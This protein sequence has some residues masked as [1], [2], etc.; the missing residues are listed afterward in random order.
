MSL[1]TVIP[2]LESDPQQPKTTE[3]EQQ[4]PFQHPAQ[5]PAQHPVHRR[6]HAAVPIPQKPLPIAQLP[7]QPIK[8]SI[9]RLRVSSSMPNWRPFTRVRDPKPVAASLARAIIEV[10][11][12]NRPCS[13]LRS[14]ATRPVYEGIA[15]RA[16][17]IRRIHGRIT[18]GRTVRVTG[19]RSQVHRGKGGTLLDCEASFTVHDGL[20]YRAVALQLTPR[21]GDWIITALEI[22]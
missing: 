16:D 14:R 11:L 5:H 20:R 17:L 6:I 19:Q 18:T 7:S 13:H 1:V 4:P 10:L 2:E 12:G 3:A 8:G 21:H 22:G 15:R 9:M